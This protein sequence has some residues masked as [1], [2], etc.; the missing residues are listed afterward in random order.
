MDFG[1]A[2]RRAGP[3]SA[4]GGRRR[5]AGENLWITG[6]AG[7]DG[8]V[9]VDGDGGGARDGG[10]SAA[11]HAGRANRLI[12]GFSPGEQRALSSSKFFGIMALSRDLSRSSAG[13]APS[14]ELGDGW[15]TPSPS[16]EEEEAET[17]RTPRGRRR[18]RAASRASAGTAGTNDVRR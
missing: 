14:F 8:G 3:A 9:G 6:R 15:V 16:P 17:A 11:A 18:T 2:R 4:G 1:P 7:V 5:G 13:S 12:D 10:A